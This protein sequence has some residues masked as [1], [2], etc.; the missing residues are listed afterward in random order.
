MTHILMLYYSVESTYSILTKE[1]DKE[2]DF[3]YLHDYGWQ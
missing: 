2:G 3:E 1:R